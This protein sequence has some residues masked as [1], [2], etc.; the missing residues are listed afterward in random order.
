MSEYLRAVVRGWWIIVACALAGL[1]GAVAFTASIQP[2]YQ[3]TVRFFVVAPPVNGQSALQSD[4]LSRGRIVSY[5][6]LVKSDQFVSRLVSDTGLG[7][8]GPEAESS[9]SASADKDTL[10]LTVEVTMP[11]AG[12]AFATATAIA[13]NFGSAVHELEESRVPT[14]A[15]TV[16]TVVSGP[17]EPGSQVSPRESLNYGLGLLVGAALGIG[18]AVT[19]RVLDRTLITPEQIEEAGGVRVLARIP[20][21]RNAKALNRILRSPDDALVTEAARRLR[22]NIDFLPEAAGLRSLTVTSATYAEGKTSVA[23][24]LAKA[25]AENGHTV[26][27]VEADLRR[28][29]LAQ[30]LGLAK[31]T[32]LSNVLS[33][34]VAADKAV[35]ESGIPG[36]QVM[37]AGTVPPRPTALLGGGPV[38]TMLAELAPKFSRIVVDA[39]PLQPMSDAAL[40]A[41]VTDGAIVVVRHQHVT[42]EILAA[43]LA[44]L[45]AVNSTLLG[46]AA[47]FLPNRLAESHRQGS[48]PRLS[49]RFRRRIRPQE[50]TRKAAAA[51][52]P[53]RDRVP[54][55][56]SHRG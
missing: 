2:M 54:A 7:V 21:G 3:S 39:T 41:A 38:R 46:V 32:G 9:I 45:R 10:L 35:Q 4:E 25:W 5:A 19:R 28:P 8:T 50:P 43:S 27:L 26:L 42:A 40:L 37:A 20:A 13:R 22:T 47:T 18:I 1:L 24:L 12:K 36:L 44:N 34:Q 56:R 31:P 11:D 17:T 6:A 55:T 48:F 29:R 23:L 53:A 33:G 15:Q 30:E 51:Q 52:N 49:G 16:L 14:T